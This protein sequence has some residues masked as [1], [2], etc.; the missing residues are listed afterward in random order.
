[1]LAELWREK[2]IRRKERDAWTG[3]GRYAPFELPP[4]APTRRDA[5]R[6]DTRI[7]CRYSTTLTGSPWLVRG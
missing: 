6:L 3:T 2:K 7:R 4:R 1:M 5:T